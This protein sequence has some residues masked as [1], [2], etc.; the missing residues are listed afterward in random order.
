MWK[1]TVRIKLLVGKAFKNQRNYGY[2]SANYEDTLEKHQQIY[3]GIMKP[4]G[5]I[6]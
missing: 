1:K 3:F 5:E 2:D 4:S 6:N